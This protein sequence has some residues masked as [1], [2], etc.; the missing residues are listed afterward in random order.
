MMI[1]VLVR[2]WDDTKS[3]LGFVR[4]I[5]EDS[6]CTVD[7]EYLSYFSDGMIY[8]VLYISPPGKKAHGYFSVDLNSGE[9]KKMDDVVS[10]FKKL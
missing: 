3:S 6:K 7:P 5:K 8:E 4:L 10:S 9:V 2:A 1:R